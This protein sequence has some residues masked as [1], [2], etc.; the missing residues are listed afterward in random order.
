MKP[1]GI[2]V[3][4]SLPAESA[5]EVSPVAPETTDKAPDAAMESN[6]PDALSVDKPKSPDL[7]DL[8]KHERFRF[9]GREMTLKE[10][11]ERQMMREDY[12]RK[13]Q[14]V[15]EARKYADNFQ[16]DLAWVLEDPTRLGKMKEVYPR[17]YVK[18]AEQI[19]SRVPTGQGQSPTPQQGQ[20]MP[21]TASLP[22]EV[23]KEIEEIREW[24][25][26]VQSEINAAKQAK[27]DAEL[28]SWFD[29][30]GKKFSEAD[31][32]VVTT[33]AQFL[34][35]QL[36]QNG[37]Q[38]TKQH[39]E[40][41]FKDDHEARE[42]RFAERVRAQQKEQ[43]AVAKKSQDIGGGGGVPGTAPKQAKTFKEARE[44]FDADLKSGRIS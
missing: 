39:L 14:A 8:D 18:I 12:T 31:A 38:F 1:F 42:K 29:E 7:I 16:T 21:S 9:Q 33:K 25:S 20:E 41:L 37:K 27:A 36:E 10:F 34:A 28:T 5:P 30:F 24:K 40:R 43:K 13:S 23:V 32:E 35:E 44:A 6:A 2:D 15:A 4:T 3:P 26:Q 17:E 11:Q 19:L 22:P